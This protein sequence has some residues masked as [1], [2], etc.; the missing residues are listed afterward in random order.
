MEIT[1]RQLK[2]LKAGKEQVSL[3]AMRFGRWAEVTLKNCRAAVKVGLNLSWMAAHLLPAPAGE[4]Y[5]R[6]TAAAWK[7]FEQESAAAQKRCN[8]EVAVAAKARRE[9]GIVT[10]IEARF[11][12]EIA[13][14]ERCKREMM[15]AGARYDRATAAAF[16]R[17]AEW[18]GTTVK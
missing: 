8:Q 3:F 9:Q 2:A 10:L 5:E 6:E 11:E 13:A 16:Y 17:A 1:V 12:Q 18:N 15:A 14:E 4:R 7:R